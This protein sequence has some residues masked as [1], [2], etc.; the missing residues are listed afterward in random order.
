MTIEY[1]NLDQYLHTT[2]AVPYCHS[3]HNEQLES[4]EKRAILEPSKDLSL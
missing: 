2:W 1:G 3:G 4:Y